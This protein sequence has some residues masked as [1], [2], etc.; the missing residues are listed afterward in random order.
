MEVI[1]LQLLEKFGGMPCRGEKCASSSSHG[2]GRKR[3]IVKKG[4]HRG[5]RISPKDAIAHF[6]AQRRQTT[7]VEVSWLKWLDKAVVVLT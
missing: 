5:G 7:V 1:I 4:D 3:S 2:Q 6:W